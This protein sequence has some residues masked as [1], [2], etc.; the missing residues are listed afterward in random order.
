M[1]L[2]VKN[3][4]PIA[5]VFRA[6]VTVPDVHLSLGDFDFGLVQVTLQLRNRNVT[7]QLHNRNVNNNVKPFV[8]SLRGSGKALKLELSPHSLALP[9]VVP[10]SFGSHVRFALTNPNDVAV[11]VYCVQLDKEYLREEA[12]TAAA[13]AAAL[14]PAAEA[15]EAAAVGDL[16]DSAPTAALPAMCAQLVLA[17]FGPPLADASAVTA[18]LAV[19]YDCPVVSL[20]SLEIIA[21]QPQLAPVPISFV[22]E[23]DEETADGA[24]SA[25]PPVHPPTT[26]PPAAIVDE[27]KPAV[28]LP[29]ALLARIVTAALAQADKDTLE[30]LRE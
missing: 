5:L 25:A 12:A 6:H 15:A 24:P 23:D 1:L 28:P 19:R 21:L 27:Q 13:T 22:D 18:A 7:L 30:L 3:G 2:D 4:A 14:A 9:A 11:E 26:L 8:V 29:R 16:V 17:V 10:H 20:D